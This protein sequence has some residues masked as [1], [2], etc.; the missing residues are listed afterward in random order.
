MLGK[1]LRLLCDSTINLFVIK[2]SDFAKNP[3]RSLM[4]DCLD[5][6]SLRFI[7]KEFYGNQLNIDTGKI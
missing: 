7:R 6:E 2:V 3:K 5:V 4:H 1:A